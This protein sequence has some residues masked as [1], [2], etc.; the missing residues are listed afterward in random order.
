M[1]QIFRPLEI[2]TAFVA[3]ALNVFKCSK[4]DLS[5]AETGIIDE[6]MNEISGLPFFPASSQLKSEF[7]I[8]L[9]RTYSGGI[10]NVQLLREF[11]IAAA[12]ARY[13]RKISA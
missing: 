12:K 8:L 4:Y 5:T 6:I 2:L 10:T 3:S 1:P 7:A 11:A 9:H 13:T